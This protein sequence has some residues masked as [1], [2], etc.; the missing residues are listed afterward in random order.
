MKTVAELC[1]PRASV[2]EDMT[3]DVVLDITNLL[4]GTIDES[5]F[6]DENFQTQGMKLLIDTAFERFQGK[7]DTGVIKLTQAMG[8]GKTHNMLALALL[9]KNPA[10]REK[11]LGGKYADVGE[12]KVIAFTGRESD[13]PFGIWGALAEQLG[14]KEL[15]KD[16]YSPLQAPGQSAWMN[17]LKGQKI[18]ILLDELPPYLDN[19]RAKQIGDSNLCKVTMTALANLFNCMGLAEMKNACLVFS[20]LKATYQAGTA[21]LQSAFKDLENEANRMARDIAP[22]ALNTDEVYDILKTR[23]FESVPVKTDEGVR[24]VAEAYRSA[25]KDA[26]KA[27]FVNLNKDHT[28][29]PDALYTGIVDSY[30]FHPSIKELYARFKENPN[31]QQ[32]RGLI[33]LMRQIVRQ[34]YENKSAETRGLINVYDIDLNNQRTL[35]F[36]R[37]IKPAL[38]N[39]VNHDIAQKGKSVTELIDQ[40]N[41]GEKFPYA[42]TFGKLVFM[43][44]LNDTLNGVNGLSERDAYG[45]LAAPGANLDE[46]RKAFDEMRSRCWYLKSDTAGRYA[47]Q[48]TKSMVAEISSLV[49]SYS[50]ELARQELMKTLKANFSPRLRNC[51]ELLYVMP[52]IDEIKLEMN[53]VAL[54]IYEP[55]AGGGLHPDLRAFYDNA[56]FKNRLLF[57]SGPKATMD[58]LYENSKRRTAIESVI[59]T[60]RANPNFTETDPQYKEASALLDKYTHALLSTI[61]ETFIELS[62]PAKDNTLQTEDFKLTFEN[63]HFDGEK[64]VVQTLADARKFEDFT[65]DP[66]KLAI[67]K[68]KCEV[69]LFTQ[70]EMRWETILERAATTTNWPILHPSQMNALKEFCF[71]T[72]AWRET[73]GYLQKGPFP[74]EP[75]AVQVEQTGYDEK[76]QEFTLKVHAVNGT[77][78]FYEIGANATTASARIQNDVLKTKETELFFLAVDETPNADE[79]HPTGE[80]LRFLCKVPLKYEQR[81]GGSGPVMELK[82]H[83][84]F[85]IRYTTDG[86][87]PKEDGGTYTGEIVL[88]E[89]CTVVLAA[90]YNH[91]TLVEEKSINVEKGGAGTAGGAKV[92]IDPEKPV[93]CAFSPRVKFTDTTA[94]YNELAFLD[95][96]NGLAVSGAQ[97]TIFDKADA[98][99]YSEL[100]TNG[101]AVTPAQLKTMLDCVRDNAFTGADITLNLAYK[102]LKF[103]A[104][105]DFLEY[106]D[107]KKLDLNTLA[108]TGTI[109]Q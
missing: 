80:G 64:Q 33:R 73:G 23:L 71:K 89:D 25:A 51:Y 1:K 104:G 99:R 61:R 74:K 4:N 60:M 79:C 69:R 93:S 36:I 21:Q 95:K 70:K 57:L 52:A 102:Q 103:K 2:F 59:D 49:D 109:E 75:T 41:K 68:Q 66:H 11:V 48:H 58:T 14:K 96:F 91:G 106:V 17:L 27:G 98:G 12:V 85:E 22:V 108:S 6:F 3:T 82:T 53:K 56:V 63:N 90:V 19:A 55:Y 42:Q 26:V 97:V 50:N 62:F 100:S 81:Q 44:S 16:L 13:A 78:V 77:V 94:V 43:A 45:Y 31:F 40:E 72:D 107:K 101:L 86:S 35:S 7:S 5:K 8:G 105:G 37:E 32:T 65:N 34:F 30:P 38:E 92:E 54:V 15:F 83:P 39:A 84:S 9:A 88:P 87:N 28:S 18:L 47:F 46:Y 24:D 20:D 10:L 29:F 76:T 67:L